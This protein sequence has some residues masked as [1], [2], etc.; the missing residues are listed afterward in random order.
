MGIEELIGHEEE[1]FGVNIIASSPSLQVWLKIP[2]RLV[3]EEL[4]TVLR[5]AVK[6]G[7]SVVGK[8]RSISL[9]THRYG[10]RCFVHRTET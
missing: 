10:L 5:R 2:S 7:D 6:V 1:K 8:N 4:S 3:L 9:I